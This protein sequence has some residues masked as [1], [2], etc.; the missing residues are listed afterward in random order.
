M[1]LANDVNFSNRSLGNYI[2]S[3][4]NRFSLN[5]LTFGKLSKLSKIIAFQN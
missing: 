1:L 3:L 5:K 4:D 2:F